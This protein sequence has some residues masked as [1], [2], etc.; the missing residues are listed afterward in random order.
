MMAS[1][2]IKRFAKRDYHDFARKTSKY[3]ISY[4]PLLVLLTCSLRRVMET[5]EDFAGFLARSA[6]RGERLNRHRIH[7]NLRLGEISSV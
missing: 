4:A 1:G 5:E 6:Q 3:R 2:S 7:D